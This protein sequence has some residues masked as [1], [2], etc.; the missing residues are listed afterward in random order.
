M[1]WRSN[2]F[3]RFPIRS[4]SSTT[5]WSRRCSRL[6]LNQPV[7]MVAR[8]DDWAVLGERLAGAG[9]T[10]FTV[11]AVRAHNGET[12]RPSLRGELAEVAPLDRP[13]RAL[14]PGS[15]GTLELAKI[16]LRRPV[17]A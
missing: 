15:A 5:C 11:L 2:S 3:A 12:V 10:R 16:S 14:A 7:L 13:L 4:S 9:V 1:S 8:P 17:R 6:I